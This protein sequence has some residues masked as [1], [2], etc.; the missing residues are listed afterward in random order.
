MLEL[1]NDS[2]SLVFSLKV[3]SNKCEGITLQQNFIGT[4][5][6]SSYFLN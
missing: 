4:S 5:Y 2:D 1:R 6:K 3:I